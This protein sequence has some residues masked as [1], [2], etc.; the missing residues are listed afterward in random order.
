MEKL[1]SEALVATELKLGDKGADL[2]PG[3]TGLAV[4]VLE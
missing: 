4:L 2:A 1:T 3:C